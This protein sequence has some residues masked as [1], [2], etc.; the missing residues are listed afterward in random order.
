VNGSDFF[1]MGG[2][3][4]YVWGSYGFTAV[5]L[6]INIIVPLRRRNAIMR[7]LRELA[8]VESGPSDEGKA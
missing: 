6:L 4:L 3:G 2:Y 5:L 7:M 8:R 1:T